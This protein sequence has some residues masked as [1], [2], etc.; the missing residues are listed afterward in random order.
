M[1]VNHT[2]TKGNLM[3][4]E[5]TLRLSKNGH[6]LMDRK[7]M[8]LMNEIMAL[9]QKSRQV[10]TDLKEA[11]DKAYQLLAAAQREIGLHTIAEWAQDVP[12]SDQLTIH[13]R[14]IMGS[15]VPD[16]HYEKQKMTPSYSFAKT[17]VEMDRAR[18]AFE[19]VKQLQIQLAQI[20]NAAYRLAFNIQK[21]QKRVNALQNITIPQLQAAQGEIASALEEKEREEFTRLKV[22]KRILNAKNEAQKARMQAE[23]A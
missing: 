1:E 22:V 10:Q 9:V 6:E 2:P 17:A 18:M 20:E 21:T 19:E 8:I 12:M 5:K 11:Y 4:I 7:R 13:V 23:N 14:S 16:L 15:E 3:Q